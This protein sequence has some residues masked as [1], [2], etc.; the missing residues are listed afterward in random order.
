MF[1]KKTVFI[2]GA[3]AS[4]EFDL[5]V[6]NALRQKTISTKMDIR[7]EHGFRPIGGGDLRPFEQ[8]TNQKRSLRNE[9]QNSAW[10]V[11]DGILLS[12]SIDGPPRPA[13]ERPPRQLV[14]QSSYRPM[15]FG[16]GTRQQVVFR[17][18]Q[19]I[20]QFQPQRNLATRGSSSSCRC[21]RLESARECPADLR[22]RIVHRLQLRP[23]HRVLFAERTADRLRHPRT[24]GA[25]R[26]WTISI[27]FI[28]TE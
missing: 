24:G 23:L 3:G 15:H 22:Q 20:R 7:F 10:L 16:G 12:R 2:V 4:A 1:K 9:F 8:I 17:H 11:R 27:S 28:L 19:P 25:E 6:G 14:R 13:Q 18:E 5:P 21:S 26:P